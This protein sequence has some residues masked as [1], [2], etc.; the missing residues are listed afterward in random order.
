[1]LQWATG[2]V[3]CCYSREYDRPKVTVARS[4]SV[5]FREA[6]RRCPSL[7]EPLD[8]ALIT[9]SALASLALTS[10]P[11][12]ECAILREDVEG[13]PDD[14]LVAIDWIGD[15][16]PENP[17]VLVL[18]FPGVGTDARRG[19]SSMIAHHLA[20]SRPCSRVGVV[21]LQGH[22]GLPLRSTRIVGLPYVGS[23]DCGHVIEH[24]SEKWAGTPIVVV[25]CSI[26]AAHFTHWAGSN[27][28]KVDRCAVCGA[29]VVCHGGN[30]Q[31]TDR[32]LV[33]SGAEPFILGEFRK[34][35]EAS[36]PDREKLAKRAPSFN[37]E[38]LLQSRTLREWTCQLLPIY[39]HADYESLMLAVDTPPDLMRRIGCPIVFLNSDNDPVTPAG[40]L[41]DELNIIEVVPNCA[42]VRTALGSH[43][44][45]WEGPPWALEQR[46]ACASMVELVSA[47]LV[48]GLPSERS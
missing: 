18:I 46:W 31:D 19:F 17:E 14:G 28:E 41:M 13:L 8:V 42:T 15:K 34:L 3:A 40:R 38:K 25:A 47:L 21:V 36:P 32:A 12:Q 33:T 6:L 9:H 44:A 27:P 10:K 16:L 23:G 43:M 24:C 35:L 39:G 37:L 1:M 29:I 30:A 7:H 22:G 5:Q 26:G 48:A 20:V 45:W 4:A 11:I 2:T